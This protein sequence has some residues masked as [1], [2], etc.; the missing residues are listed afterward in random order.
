MPNHEPRSARYDTTLPWRV[1]NHYCKQFCK[2]S[3][4]QKNNSCTLCVPMF[5]YDV[6]KL[7]VQ[8]VCSACKVSNQFKNNLSLSLMSLFGYTISKFTI[9]LIITSGPAGH[10]MIRRS[11]ASWQFNVELRIWLI[12][13]RFPRVSSTTMSSFFSSVYSSEMAKRVYMTPQDNKVYAQERVQFT[14]V[15]LN[16]PKHESGYVNNRVTVFLFFKR[17]HARC[18]DTS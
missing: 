10:V 3:H 12:I 5:L 6:Y 18:N 15:L 8:C 17:L 11:K 14:Y 9:F 4:H 1:T 2:Y 13:S 7:H 16:S